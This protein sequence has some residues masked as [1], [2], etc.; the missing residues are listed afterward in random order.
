MYRIVL[1][2]ATGTILLLTLACTETKE[3]TPTS[4]AIMEDTTALP[5]SAT[6]VITGIDVQTSASPITATPT[7]EPTLRP[8]QPIPETTGHITRDPYPYS[9]EQQ[10][11]FADIVVLATFQSIAAGTE[12]MPAPEGEQPTYRPV[13]TMTFRASEYLKGT[14]P[15]Q[16]AVELRSEGYETYR[17]DGQLY[18]GYLTESDAL[19]EAT[20]LTT[21][22]NTKYDDRLGILFL[23]GPITPVPQSE[24]ESTSTNTYNFVLHQREGSFDYSVDTVSRTWLPAKNALSNG[25]T[26][27]SESTEYIRDGTRTPPPVISLSAVRTLI[28][29]IDAVLKKGEGIEGWESC[30]Y[31]MFWRN[32]VQ[33]LYGWNHPLGRETLIPVWRARPCRGRIKLGIAVMLC[34]GL[35]VQMEISLRVS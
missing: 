4:V 6:A 17:I 20:R 35:R 22:R 33:S 28:A 23:M 10:I 7:P 19:A 26:G 3:P 9:L 24:G 34:I 18:D 29:E 2:L 14:G 16:F 32:Q 25:A 27:I 11:M 15:N 8:P 30:I 13:L 5:N 21:E 12:T 31:G 1:T